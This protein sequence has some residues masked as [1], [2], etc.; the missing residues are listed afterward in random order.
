ME[1]I[2][3]KS[4]LA[5]FIAILTVYCFFPYLRDVLKG[6]TKPH[7][8]TWIIFTITSSVGFASNLYGHG[9]LASIPLGIVILFN[10]TI[11]LLSIKHGTKDINFKD[12]ILMFL[13]AV[14]II[15]WYVFNNPFLS[16]F[17]ATLVDA[18]GYFPTFRKTWSEPGSETKSFWFMIGL[19]Q[20]LTIFTN[21]EYNFYT[22]FYLVVVCIFSWLVFLIC[23]LRKK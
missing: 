2:T 3:V 15:I 22:C 4:L 23:A 19:S 11:V 20:F 14:S 1:I 18:L 9:G 16:V 21:T 10:A 13:A 17:M 7:I 8:Y 5:T 12:K 6:N